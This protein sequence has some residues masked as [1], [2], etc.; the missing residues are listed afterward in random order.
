MKPIS[1]LS[2]L[3]LTLAFPTLAQAYVGPGAGIG[4]I[5]AFVGVLICLVLAVFGF[6]WYPIKRLRQKRKGSKTKSPSN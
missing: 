4:A 1:L 3:L 2:T 5:V 6:L